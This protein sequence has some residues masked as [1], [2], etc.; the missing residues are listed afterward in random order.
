MR[1]DRK[2]KKDPEKHGSSFLSFSRF[3]LFPSHSLHASP[4][5]KR[6]RRLQ[7]NPITFASVSAF[8]PNSNQPRLRCQ[9]YKLKVVRGNFFR[10][11]TPFPEF[12]SFFLCI[13]GRMSPHFFFGGGAPEKCRRHIKCA[14][15]SIHLCGCI[16]DVTSP[17]SP[18]PL[19]NVSGATLAPPQS[20]S[21]R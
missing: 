19:G 20:P 16:I 2:E 15:H 13:C 8:P 9:K 1:I 18:S 3:V 7:P 21:R 5:P 11:C 4:R 10:V 17:L 14:V 12:R 6:E